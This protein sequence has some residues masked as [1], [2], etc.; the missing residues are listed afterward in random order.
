MPGYQGRIFW[1][2]GFGF[3]LWV[4]MIRIK[5]REPESGLEPHFSV[6]RGA[7]AQ[8]IRSAGQIRAGSGTGRWVRQRGGS[9]EVSRAWLA[10]GP[11][12]LK[13]LAAARLMGL[14]HAITMHAAPQGGQAGVY[15]DAE[16]LDQKENS[17][18]GQ[19]RHHCG[20]WAR[21]TTRERE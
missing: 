5:V 21:A 10:P 4:R 14:R 9:H 13:G 7:S 17:Y 18:V 20:F 11:A 6:A 19:A 3:G 8:Q 2:W 15:T 12:P 16:D 1:R